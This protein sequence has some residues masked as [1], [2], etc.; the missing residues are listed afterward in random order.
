MVDKIKKSC[1]AL[2][3]NWL[4][5]D[6]LNTP[7]LEPKENGL[8]IVSMLCHA[9]VMMYLL[10]IK[11]FYRRLL[12]GRI[13]IINDGTLNARDIELL[14]RH[15]NPAEFIK[16]ESLQSSSCPT[17]ISWKKLFCIA[18][19][20]TDSFAIQLDSDTLTVGDIP[21]VRE[22]VDS[23]TSFILGTWK[24]QEIG[25]M[26]EAREAVE[27]D[28]SQHVQMVAERNFDKLARF[29][30]LRYVRGCSGFDGFAKNLFE[31]HDLEELSR[32]MFQIIGNKW[33]EWGSEQTASN[34]IIANAERA[35]VLPYPQYYSYWGTV[36]EASFIHFVGTHRYSGGIYLQ[37]AKKVIKTLQG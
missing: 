19:C 3:F 31:L 4:V 8:T 15:V 25:S 22:H 26:A 27:H 23:G 28:P 13:V 6:I 14:K 20:I 37:E 32:Q 35:R 10:A 5:K 17:Y 1:Q 24:N 12:R 21:E 18:N 34:I 33:N 2:I 7:P 11:S 16:A 36:E 9:D 29:S 30:S